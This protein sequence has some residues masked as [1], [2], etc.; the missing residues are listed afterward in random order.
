MASL[1]VSYRFMTRRAYHKF[2]D[3][4]KYDSEQILLEPKTK[5][6]AER[7]NSR[8]KILGHYHVPPI[9]CSD[10]CTDLTGYFGSRSL[11]RDD[12]PELHY[13]HSRLT[14]RLCKFSSYSESCP[15][16]WFRCL[17]KIVFMND[18]KP[19]EK[20]E[21]PTKRGESQ[22]KKKYIWYEMGIFSHWGGSSDRRV[23][24]IDTPWYFAEALRAALFE[25]APNPEDP[26]AL[27]QPLIDELVKLCDKSVW[28]IR[29]V[30]RDVETVC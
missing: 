7:E 6:Q 22:S 8:K 24:C 15:D 29:N 27:L 10:M 19:S 16:A 5:P 30:V 18:E 11:C 25:F 20:D 21:S 17:A 23:L 2:E 4:K 1:T 3:K 9:L 12:A 28:R 14:S 13:S 26:F